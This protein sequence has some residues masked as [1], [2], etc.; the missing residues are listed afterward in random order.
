MPSLNTIDQ[1]NVTSKVQ[2]TYTNAAFP[3][4]SGPDAKNPEYVVMAKHWQPIDYLKLGTLGMREA[5]ARYLPKYP[6]ESDKQHAFRVAKAVL[7]GAY[8][9]TVKSMSQ[10]PFITPVMLPEL[11]PQLEY[12]KTNADTQGTDFDAFSK[13]LLQ[14]LFDYGKCHILV[15]FPVAPEGI[16]RAQE[17]ALNLKP[18]FCRIAPTSVIG[19]D[20]LSESV[21]G[22]ALGSI[23]IAESHYEK[24]PENRY[25]VNKVDTIR[26]IKPE[27]T[28]VWSVTETKGGVTFWDKNVIKTS[29]KSIPLITIYSNRT[30]FMTSQPLLEEL[31]HLNIQHWQ[32]SSDV[33]HS[34]FIANIPF[35]FGSGFEKDTTDLE[36][37]QTMIINEKVDA[38]LAYVEHSGSALGVAHL[39][40][41]EIEQRMIAMGADLLSERGSSTRETATSKLV[42]NSKTMSVLQATVIALEIGLEKALKL[43][44]DWLKIKLPIGFEVNIGDKMQLTQDANEIANLLRAVELG[45]ISEDDFVSELQRRG[46]LSSTVIAGT[47][48]QPEPAQKPGAKKPEAKPTKEG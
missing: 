47:M 9:R 48:I 23:R 17:L 30:G 46:K 4:G 36:I 26:E 13:Q 41:K 42:D 37:G 12:M 11:P 39:T 21:D 19:W 3:T 43:A 15:E 27:E 31:A 22:S 38:K 2:E 40:I 35:L 1:T 8:T 18:Y 10:L 16:N 33:E 24:D 25:V 44:A 14:D 45:L 32:K 5:G 20:E 6:N 34:E 29:S 28:T 7:Y